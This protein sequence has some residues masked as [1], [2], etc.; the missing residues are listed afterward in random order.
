MELGSSNLGWCQV[1]DFLKT[2]MNTLVL[3][4]A[5]NC[6]ITWAIPIFQEKLS[7]FISKFFRSDVYLMK[8][9]S[10]A[11]VRRKVLLTF[12]LSTKLRSFRTWKINTYKLHRTVVRL[13]VPPSTYQLDGAATSWKVNTGSAVI[14]N[15]RLLLHPSIYLHMF[16]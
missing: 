3:Y 14:E 4:K 13:R 8:I 10:D 11:F 15:S 16:S 9:G 12:F 7:P 6:L 2:A 1:A 5:V